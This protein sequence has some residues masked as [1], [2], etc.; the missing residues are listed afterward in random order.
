MAMKAILIY[1]VDPWHSAS[2]R[3]LIAVATTERNRDRL[4]R[5]YLREY[6]YTKAFKEDIDGAVRQIR[7]MSQTQC[8]SERFDFENL[9]EQ[10]ETNVIL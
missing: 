2:S 4:V 10:T 7:E 9:T 8:L 5:K 3:E 1:T 6:T